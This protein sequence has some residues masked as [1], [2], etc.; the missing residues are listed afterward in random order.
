MKELLS[1]GLIRCNGIQCFI[2]GKRIDQIC[3]DCGTFYKYEH[4]REWYSTLRKA[5]NAFD[6]N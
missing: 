5:I 1:R 2:G 3:T 4:G 6:E